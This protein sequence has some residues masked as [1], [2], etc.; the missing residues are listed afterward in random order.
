MAG[1]GASR[2]RDM[3]QRDTLGQRCNACLYCGMV[4]KKQVLER[5]YVDRTVEQPGA[6][7]WRPRASREVASLPRCGG[8]NS[9]PALSLFTSC[10]LLHV[11][12]G[13]SGRSLG[14]TAYRSPAL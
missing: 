4:C 9:T 13:E 3:D 14:R 2:S 6:S 12:R 10:L 1:R 11:A 7:H 5:L 8:P